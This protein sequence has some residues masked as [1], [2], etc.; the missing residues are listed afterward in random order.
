[1]SKITIYVARHGKTLMNTLDMV[2]GWCDSPLTDEGI[3]VAEQLGKGLAHISFRTAYCSTLRRTHQ[4]IEIVLK[5]AGQ[6]NVAVIEEDGFKEAGFGSFEGKPNML[7][8]GNAALFLGYT[9]YDVMY[10]DIFNRK[11]STDKVLDAI[12]KLDTME[13]AE[14]AETLRNR[15]QSTLKKV[16][17]EE[18]KK[19]DGNI[20][21]V[22]HGMSI[23]GMLGT[24]GGNE[25]LKG[26]LANAAVCKVIYEDGKFTVESMGDMSYVERGKE[27]MSKP[28]YE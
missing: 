23:L 4:T 3:K 5:G 28:I 9:S 17:E 22:S 21:I 15:T 8:W 13:L 27:L 12:R 1:M 11:I 16:A 19:G 7:M 26:H 14:D 24:L 10:Q 25:I 2:Q 20:L 6:S 18:A